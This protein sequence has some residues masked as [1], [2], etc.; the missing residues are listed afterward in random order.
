M[1]VGVSED[2]A[3]RLRKVLGGLSSNKEIRAKLES[4]VK[5]SLSGDLEGALGKLM[6]LKGELES[7][8]AIIDHKVKGFADGN[9]NPSHRQLVKE[10][11]EK[12]GAINA[13]MPLIE[14]QIQHLEKV[15][16]RRGILEQLEVSKSSVQAALAG[17]DVAERGLKIAEDNAQSA[18]RSALAA[19]SSA[20]AAKGSSEIAHKGAVHTRRGVWVASGSAFIAALALCYQVYSQNSAVSVNLSSPVALQAVTLSDESI[21]NLTRALSVE[22]AKVKGEQVTLSPESIE[23][24]RAVLSLELERDAHIEVVETKENV[25]QKAN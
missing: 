24:L 10:V 23:G 12:I 11:H 5:E 8:L 18:N 25:K 17:V 3:L 2:E 21:N 15:M 16:D 1:E 13:F 9:D 14:I 7:Q 22:L 19:E 4:F 6:A 20:Q